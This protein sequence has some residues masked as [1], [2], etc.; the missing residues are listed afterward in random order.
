MLRA[1]NM[2]LIWMAGLLLLV[3]VSSAH[4]SEIPVNEICTRSGDPFVGPCFTVHGRMTA[5]G[6]NIVVRIWP[7]GTHRLFGY[8]DGALQC[9]FPSSVMTLL[10]TGQS[11]Y[12]D[13]IV[14]PV[15][16]SRPGFMQFV[17]VSSASKI[18][19]VPTR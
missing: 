10:Q 1:W 9:A 7:V 3:A 8:A 6:D 13:I 11:V 12:A 15:T 17:C 19:R 14:R 4:A 16:D 2:R 18:V 5:G